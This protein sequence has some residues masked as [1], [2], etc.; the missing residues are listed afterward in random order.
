MKF[1]KLT[2]GLLAFGI[3]SATAI[4]AFAANEVKTKLTPAERPPGITNDI[5]AGEIQE[6]SVNEN[7][8]ISVEAVPAI[9][10]IK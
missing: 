2:A 3:M 6:N 9:Q 1:K 10:P 7:G 8:P 5:G 4:T